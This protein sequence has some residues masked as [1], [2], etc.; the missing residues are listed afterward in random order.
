MS[1]SKKPVP[2]KFLYQRLRRQRI[3]NKRAMATNNVSHYDNNILKFK[4]QLFICVQNIT[5]YN[6]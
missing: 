1:R 3:M 5:S 2:A 6:K 4:K